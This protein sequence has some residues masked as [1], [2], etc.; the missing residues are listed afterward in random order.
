MIRTLLAAAA[1]VSVCGLAAADTGYVEV[2]KALVFDAEAAVNPKQAS[3]EL[4]SLTRQAREACTYIS[5]MGMSPLVDRTCVKD[6]LFQ[7]VSSINSPALEAVYAAS[8]YYVET[9]SDRV[10]LASVQ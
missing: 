10:E 7:A 4:D 1:A 9:V 6:M 3:G 5:S 8:P 2:T